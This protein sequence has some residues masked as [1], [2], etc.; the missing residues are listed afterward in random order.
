[1][2]KALIKK[3]FTGV[4]LALLAFV[5]VRYM[6]GRLPG[7]GSDSADELV[8]TGSELES[9]AAAEGG[10]S[11]TEASGHS[12][13]SG[14]QDTLELPD[15]QN[16]IEVSPPLSQDSG[17]QSVSQLPDAVSQVQAGVPDQQAPPA[18]SEVSRDGLYNTKK[19]VALYIKT[20]GCLPKNYITKKEAG[21]LGWTGGNPE[22]VKEKASIGGDTYSNRE[23]LLP[24]AK[25]RTYREC[26]I[27]T[28]GKNSR[29]ARR[30][31]FSNDGYIFYTD[32]HYSSFEQLYGPE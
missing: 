31:V 14:V 32:D 11:V 16:Q 18:Q 26:D 25:G 1:M 20:Y 8:V 6:L 22:Y 3:I 24:K 12:A 28:W 23:G 10:L 7:H 27:D 21:D 29:G 13:L 17:V 19:K 5:L 15:L 9:E 2:N 30:I 4:L